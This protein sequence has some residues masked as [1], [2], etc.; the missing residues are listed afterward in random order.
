MD[1]SAMSAGRVVVTGA[2]GFT[3]GHACRH[4]SRSGWEVIAI[5]SPR[6]APEFWR[7]IRAAGGEPCDLTDGMAVRSLIGR[8]RPEAVLH[9]AGQN[10]VDVSWKA[11]CGTLAANLISTVHLLEAV[12]SERPDSRVVIAGSMVRPADDRLG[13]T[14]N[15]YAFSKTL[16]FM[17]SQAWHRW[18]GLRVVVA[19][20]SNLIG[21]GGSAGICGKI[22]RWAAEAE[23]GA[24]VRPFTL[25]SLGEQRDFLDVRDAADA[26]GLL[27]RAGEPGR[28]YA[29]E[30]GTFRTLEE[31]KRTFEE[32]A[33]LPLQWLIGNSPAISPVSRDTGPIR[34]LGWRPRIPFR[35]SVKETLD[36][37][38]RRIREGGGRLP[39]P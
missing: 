28:T 3:G 33:R 16:Q 38:R 5:G 4:L 24:E 20:P 29:L 22:A 1:V 31:V 36:E 6:S 27:L 9:L 34:S 25:S 35:Q 10:A 39:K 17:A 15:P 11:P 14:T 13:E 37:E 18:Y 21:P 19:E 2:G 23:T 8:L 7:G 26:Y 30:S 12:R 32:E